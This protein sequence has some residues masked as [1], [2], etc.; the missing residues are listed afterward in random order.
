MTSV[1]RETQASRES[2]QALELFAFIV[3]CFEAETAAAKLTGGRTRCFKK[4]EGEFKP[5][6]LESCVPLSSRLRNDF[7][8][9]V[10]ALRDDRHCYFG[11]KSSGDRFKRSAHQLRY[12][13]PAACLGT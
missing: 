5:N 6:G 12:F 9:R 4:A 3:G 8:I 13:A 1:R 7:G 2:A 10:G 11:T